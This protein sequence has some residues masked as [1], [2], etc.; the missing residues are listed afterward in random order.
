MKIPV[1]F[2][3]SLD[4]RRMLGISV[5]RDHVQQILI[6]RNQLAH[7][8]TSPKLPP[9]LR[10][11]HICSSCYALDTCIIYHKVQFSD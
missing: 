9:M 7:Y 2:L 11:E 1:G 6:K 3:V 8:L 5:T 10:E 4:Q